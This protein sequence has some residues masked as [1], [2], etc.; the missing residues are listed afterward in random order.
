MRE[1][2]LSHWH[3]LYFLLA[4][5]LD[6]SSP[7]LMEGLA[8]TVVAAAAVAVVAEEVVAA[9]GGANEPKNLKTIGPPLIAYETS[10]R[11]SPNHD[12]WRNPCLGN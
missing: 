10:R 7:A 2:R 6:S 9:V 11:F 8:V 1:D 3:T 12:C 5:F 4:S